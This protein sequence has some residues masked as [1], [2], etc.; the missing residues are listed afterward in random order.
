[1]RFPGPTHR[2]IYVGSQ[3]A[4]ERTLASLQTWI[5]KHMRLKVNAAK[6]GTGRVWERKFLGFRMD[7]RKRIG[8]APES[9][10]RF[11]AKVREKW[12]GRA[13]W[14]EDAT[15]RRLESLRA[16]LV[17]I[18]PTGGGAAAAQ[19]TGPKC[20]WLRWHDR[21]GRER[22]LRRL[23]VT[24]AS[25]GVATS[26]R[27][28]WGVAG[29]PE[30]Q[31]GLRNSVLRRHGSS[32]IGSCRAVKRPGST[33]G[34]GKPHVRWCVRVAGRNPRHSTRSASPPR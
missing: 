23:G 4:A 1:V 13:E 6:S 15:A 26:S 33:A 3:A 27:G 17:G 18:L 32:T 10:E 19:A 7:R 31:W 30:L 29:Q 9:L 21:R 25:L 28:A 20:F 24:G 16:R 14:H 34:C 11:K 8:I 5:E 22:D 12:D 2:N